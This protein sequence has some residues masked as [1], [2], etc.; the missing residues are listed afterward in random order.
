MYTYLLYLE[1]QLWHEML[2]L[3]SRQFGRCEGPKEQV[4]ASWLNKK[5]Q[6]HNNNLL[7]TDKKHPA[8]IVK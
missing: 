4:N 7:F 1:I 2:H 5:K 6:Q 3:F 8:T